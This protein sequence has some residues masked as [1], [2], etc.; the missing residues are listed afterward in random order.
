MQF[1]QIQTVIFVNT[2]CYI[3]AYM[4]ILLICVHMFC[5]QIPESHNMSTYEHVCTYMHSHMHIYAR[6]RT[7]YMHDTCKIQAL[8]SMLLHDICKNG[9]YIC[10]Y[11]YVYVYIMFMRACMFG[12]SSYVPVSVRICMYLHVYACI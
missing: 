1:A 5:S 12:G 7:V 10:M 3:R 2:F 9:Y 6:I 4:L 11:M 8:F